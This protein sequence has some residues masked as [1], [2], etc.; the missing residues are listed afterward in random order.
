VGLREQIAKNAGFKNYLQ[1]A[2]RARGRFDYTP[3]DCVKFHD[4][5]QREV[6]PILR[7]LQA[8]RRE[9]LRV[10]ALKPWDLSVDPLSRPPLKPFQEVGQMASKTQSI[11]NRLAGG[12]AQ[13]FQTM[14]DRRLLALANRNVKASGGYDST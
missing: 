9:L 14:Q 5:I 7:Q 12:L 1:Y 3:E 8:R 13:G 2:F 4:A 11:F 10:P 6:M